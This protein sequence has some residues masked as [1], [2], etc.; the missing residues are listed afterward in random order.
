WVLRAAHAAGVTPDHVIVPLLA[1]ASSLIGTA[2]RIKAS[3]TWFEPLTMWTAIVGESGTGK[4]PGLNAIKRALSLIERDREHHGA[5]RQR[6]HETEQEAAKVAE[7]IWRAAV[8]EAIAN[9]QAVPPKPP[10]A[11]NP[12]QFIAPRLF[13]SNATIERLA[14]L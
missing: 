10:E 5:E 11:T 13:V 9:G 3:G 2:R 7:A 1:I 4:T 12:G 8:E 14:V 6:A